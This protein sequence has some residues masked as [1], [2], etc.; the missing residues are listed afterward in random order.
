MSTT[1]EKLWWIL[2]NNNDN[3][4]YPGSCKELSSSFW[5]FRKVLMNW[6][7]NTWWNLLMNENWSWWSVDWG[8]LTSRIGSRTRDWSTARRRQLRLAGSGRLSVDMTRR[9]EPDCFSLWLDPA[10]FR[11]RGSKHCR[12]QQELLVQDYSLFTWSRLTSTIFPR[13][14]LALTGEKTRTWRFILKYLSCRLDLPPYP[15][16]EI[17]CDKLTQAVEETCG[18]AVE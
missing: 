2:L 11:S 9:W 5:L 14:T 12:D 7:L 3:F 10:E 18:F 17:M 15:S 8:L 16:E 4:Y 13:L 1:G 6:F